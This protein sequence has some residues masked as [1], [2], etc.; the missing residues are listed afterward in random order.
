MTVDIPFV[1]QE[2]GEENQELW[3]QFARKCHDNV[4]SSHL[5]PFFRPSELQFSAYRVHR[6]KQHEQH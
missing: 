2:Q 6:D 4:L 3:Q 1:T 5:H